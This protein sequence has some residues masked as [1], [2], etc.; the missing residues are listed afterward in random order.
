VADG[1]AALSAEAVAGTPFIPETYD[2]DAEGHLIVYDGPQENGFFYI[3]GNKQYGPQLIFYEYAYYYVGEDDKYV[4]D[5]SAALSAEVVAG[6]SFIPETY[7]FDAEGR[8][9][10]YDGPRA[11]GTLYIKGNKQYGP[12]LIEYAYDFYYVDANHTYVKDAYV[13]L[14]ADAV[15]GTPFGAG[16]YVFDAEGKMTFMEGPQE[17]G[18]FYLHGVKQLAYKLIEY[19]G[20][21]YFIDN[22]H[23]YL[24][25]KR[26]YLSAQFLEGTDFTPGYYEFQADGKLKYLDGPQSDGTF[27]INGIQKLCYQLIEYK[28]DYY[29]IDNGHKYLKDKRVYLSAQFLEGTDF[30]P[31][32][33]E[34]QADGKL[35]YLNGPQ[36]DGT[37]YVNGIQKLAYQLVEYEGDYYFIDNGHRY[38]QDKRVYLSAQFLEGTDFTPGYYEFQ[39]DGKLKYLNGPQSDGTFYVNGIQ[40]LC[41]QLV[42]YEG[43][44]YFIDNGHKYLKDKRVYLSAQ[45]LEGTDFTA[46]YYT[47]D[48]E[49]K[50][51][52]LDGP[53]SDGTFYV[54]G[55]Q[56]LCYQLV[57]HKGNYYF[58]DNGHKYLK[59]KRVYLSAQ[60]LEGT[61][62]KS[63][64]YNFDADGKMLLLNGPQADGYFY[65]NGVV[66]PAYQL[67]E[68]EGHY[69]FIDNGDKYL[70]N[71]QVHLGTT[72]LEGTYLLPGYY[73]FDAEG[74]MIGHIYGIF[75]GRDLGDIPF[76]VTTDGKDIKSGVLIRGG[77]LDNVHLD[78]Q[79]TD[80]RRALAINA[81]TNIYGVK[82]DM[83]LRSP[84]IGGKDMLGESVLHKYYDMVLY[85]EAFTDI[86]KE[87]VKAIFTDLA[88]PDNYPIYLHC[89]H[90]A[91][92]AGTI[93]YILEAALG[94]SEQS[95][96]RE[97][98]LSV[99]TYGNYILKVRDG[100]KAYGKPTL[101][102]CAE[103][104][105]LDCGITM[106]Q[107]QTIRSI[108]LE[109]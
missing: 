29:F 97:Y 87:K 95:A 44:Y 92:R 34:F 89:T 59:D 78:I 4:A 88:N 82:M 77:E 91:D 90:G 99:R 18:T 64:Y 47:F 80:E 109:Q 94:V 60:F 27:Y 33:Y 100:L 15:A 35:N 24:K 65:K 17:D 56:K 5:G 31:G 9:I 12:K 70:K 69:Y 13:Y 32:Y 45:F 96:L 37:F 54:N 3:E 79:F 41:Y 42:E 22:G 66:Q 73:E 20:D 105:L 23:K 36:S 101:K 39:A 25:D 55:V 48:A 61:G 102:E 75:N 49:G 74:K 68:Y 8:L 26:V 46:G 14:S 2:F 72:F 58:I 21:Y 6:T 43:N 40:K 81:L 1:S 62:L 93:C 106:E 53:Q 85:D 108:F 10:V 86:G 63:G 19:K 103:A 67:V 38:L 83:D 71:K 11:N 50:L 51:N 57:E 76:M 7:D 107:I 30:T 104:Y 28:G 84:Y 52:N 98:L 16:A